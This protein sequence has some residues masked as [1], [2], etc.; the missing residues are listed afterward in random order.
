MSVYHTCLKLLLDSSDN[1]I[2]KVG[3]VNLFIH[4]YSLSMTNCHVSVSHI[5]VLTVYSKVSSSSLISLD[6]TAFCHIFHVF[7]DNQVGIIIRS[8]VLISGKCVGV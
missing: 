1:I 6:S 2:R 5:S 8:A 3:L 4:Y 7:V